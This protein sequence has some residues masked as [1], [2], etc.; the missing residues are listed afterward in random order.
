MRMTLELLKVTTRL[1]DNLYDFKHQHINRYTIYKY[2]VKHQKKQLNDLK[3]N[4]G[5]KQYSEM[6]R[7]EGRKCMLFGVTCLAVV[8]TIFMQ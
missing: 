6:G 7:T 3:M 1:E 8:H 2:G 5:E 4:F